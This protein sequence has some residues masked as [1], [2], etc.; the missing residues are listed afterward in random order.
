MGE[1]AVE[2]SPNEE[3][4]IKMHVENFPQKITFKTRA[5]TKSKASVSRLLAAKTELSTQRAHF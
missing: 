4:W 1:A 3:I 2:S 5:G